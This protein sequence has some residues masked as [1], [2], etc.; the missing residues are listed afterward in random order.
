MLG[1]TANRVLWALAVAGAFLLLPLTAAAQYV[2]G[3]GPGG[4]AP[5]QFVEPTGTRT[6][7]AFPGFLGGMSVTLGDVNGDGV[8]DVIAGAGPGGT[9]HIKVFNGTDLSELASFLA[10]DPGFAGGVHVA[11]GD[12]DGDGRADIIIGAG[13]GGGPHV[14]VFSGA[15]LSEI[16]GFFAYNPLFDGGV[17]V[18]AGDINGD[19]RSDIVTGAGAGGGPHVRVF[20]GLDLSELAGFFAYDPEFDGG[21]NVAAG[22]IDGDGLSD[23][24]TAPGPGGGPHVRV[25]SGLDL[26]ELAG[27]YAFNPAFGGGVRVATGDI[28]G[29]G[30]VDLIITALDPHVRILSG[31]DLSEL[32]SFM[33]SPDLGAGISIGSTGDP[34]GL[35]FTSA[36]TTTFAA[37]SAGTFTVTTSGNPVP[38]I[39]QTGT[40]PAGVTFTD[41]GDGT[42]T[43]AGT[44]G[45]GSGG[46][47]A[48]T[49]TADN[50]G[51]TRPT[52]SFTLTVNEAPAITSAAATNFTINAAGT[53]A[54]TTSGFPRPAITRTGAALPAGVIWVDN[55]DGTGTLSGTPDAS[56][57]GTYAIT[58]TA[59][60]GVSP[61]ATQSFTLT[62]SG[63][64]TITSAAAATF[65]VGSAGSFTVT[66]VA[67]PTATISQTGTL[68]GNVAFTPNPDGTG[69]LSG[70][71]LAGT[72]GTYPLTFTA[73]NSEGTAT[74]SFTLT[75]HEAPAITSP[76]ATT[77]TVGSAGSFTVVMT[78]VPAPTVSVTAG[79]LPSGV[80]LSP[81]GVL[82]GTPDPGTGGVY[83]PTFTATNGVGADAVQVFTLTVNQAPAITSA[84]TASFVVN[85]AAT[86]FQVVMT[87]FPAPTVSVTAGTLPTG[88]TLSPAG[89]LSGTPTQ[90]GMFPVTLTA[91]N[92]T[93]P[94]ATQA[95][96]VVV[97]APPAIT[98]ANATTFRVG[99]AGSFTV[100]MTGVPAPTVSVTG[101][102]LPAGVTLSPAG[103]LSGT[104][105]PGTAGVYNLTFTATNG[106]GAN[107]VQPFT[108]TVG[109]VPRI[110]LDAND[111]GGTTGTD[112]AITFTEGGAAQFIE[113]V[114]DAT[115]TDVDSPTLTSITVTITNVLDALQE[116]LDV[117]LVT[118]G[119]NANFTKAFDETTTPGV[120][121]LTITTTTPQ[122]IADFNTLLRR[123][124]YQNIDTTGA[125]ATAPRTITFVV[126]DGV[127]NSNTATT[128]VTIAAGDN[129][130][131]ADNDTYTVA[132]GGT[133]TVPAPGVLDGDV[134]PEGDAPITAVLV[135]SPA[136]ASSFTLNSDGSFTYTHNGSETTT[137]AFTYRAVANG[138]QSAPATV[139]I[140][141]TAV[142]DAPTAGNDVN[143]TTEDA[144]VT[145]V[146]PGV[147]ANDTDPEGTTLTVGTVNGLAANV[148]VAV[149]LA[150]GATVTLNANGSYTYNPGNAF[151][152]LTAGQSGTDTFSYTAQDGGGAQS[153]PATVTI[154]ITGVND[155]PAGTNASVTINEDATHVFTVANFGFTDPV[156]SPANALLAV[157][158]ATLPA[159]GTLTLSGGA[160][161]VGQSI[162]VANVTAGNLVFTPAANG[163]G[164]PYTSFTFQV[165]DDG[166]TANG[167][168]DL[169]PSANTLTINVTAI[170]DAPAGTNNTVTML[171]DATRAFTVADFGFT[172]PTDAP[173]N[174][175]QSVLITTLPAAGTITL[176]G[177]GITAG[178]EIAVANITAGQLAFTPAANASGTP[179]TS[180]TFQVRDNGG[181]ANG[182][183]DLDA[184]PNTLTINVTALNDAPAGTN[185]TVTTDE[186]V[187]HIFTVPNFGFT[188]PNDTPANTLQS[189]VITTL[190]AV[191][192]L[193]LSGATFAAGTEILVASITAGNL[194]YLSPPNAF[195]SPFTTFTFQVRDNGGTAS[196]GVDLDPSANTM[197]INV[198]PVNDA[199]TVVN[200]TFEVLGNTEL[201]VDM[202]PGTT[203]HTSE[204][205]PNANTVEGVL[206]ND[207][208]VEGD[209][210]AVTGIA[211]C[212]VP[213]TTPPFDCTLTNGAVVHVA[214][215]GEFSY[216]PAP[217]AT[218][219]SFTYTVTDTPAAGIPVSVTGTVTLTLFDMI[220]YVDADA[221]AGG[222]GT[223][224]LPFNT[225]T[226]ATLSGAN[227]AGDL[228]DAD[229]YIFVHSAT[230]AIN[231]G[232]ELEVGQ[233]LIGEPAGLSIPRN[234]NSNG[235]PTVVVPVS[236]GT[237]P[238]IN[239][240]AGN[241]VTVTEAMPAEI[242][243][244]T[245]GSL[246]A[247]DVTTDAALPAAATL[248]IANNVI[249]GATAEGIDVNLNAGTTGTLTLAIT[250]NTWNQAGTHA[251]NAVDISRAAGTLNLNFSSNTNILSANAAGAAVVINGGAAIST[252]ITGFAANS[253]DGNT[254]GGGV[255]ISNVTFDATPGGTADTVNAG[256]LTVGTSIN[257]IGGAG[258][259]L[260]PVAGSLSFADLD[261]FAG[262][263]GL[264]AA[265]LNLSVAPNVST[266]SA[267]NGVGVDFNTGTLDLRLGGLTVTSAAAG[268][269]LNALAAGSQFSAATGSSIT[270]TS[271]A[272]TAFSVASS[273]VTLSYAGSLNVTSGT[274][275]SLT[276]NNAASTFTFSGGMTLTTGANPAFT[277]TG[278][279][280]V[281]VCDENPCNPAVGT[282][283]NTITTTTGTA[284]N[285]ANTTIGAGGLTFRS[286]SSGV[287]AGSGPANGINLNTTG[288]LGGL[289]ITG[290]GGTCTFATPTCTGGTIQ[291]STGD[292]IRLVSTQGVSLTRMRIHDND[293]N[294]IYGDE[295][296]NFAL[297]DSVVSDNDVANPSAFE[298]GVKFNELYGTNSISNTVV[299]GTKGDNIRLEMASGTLTNLTL[300]SV[301]VGPTANVGGGFSNGFS[302]VTSG[303]PGPTV[304]V[305]VNT[306]L[307]TGLDTTKQQSSGILTS[308]GGGTTTLSILN[309]DFEHENIG[310]DL[311]AS[312]GGTHRFNVDNNDVTFH[313]TNAIN[314]V[315][316]GVLN[317]TVN[318]NRVGNGT[319]DSGSMNSF[320]IAASQ[321]GNATWA[322]A[323]TNNT[324]RNSDFEGIFVRTGDFLT[325][326]SGTVNLTLTGNT[327]FTPDDNSGFPANPKGMHLRSRQATTLCMNIANNEA[328]GNGAAGYHLQESDT[329]SLRFQDF[330]TNAVTTLTNKNNKTAG[331]A[332]T[333]NE[334]G[335]PFA[336]SCTPTLPSFP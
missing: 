263:S 133:L 173:A 331:G 248:T 51:A 105:D 319:V 153:L 191:G 70:T 247:I 29:D 82:S 244:L 177:V 137:D 273:N 164:T 60:N 312:A 333:T 119:F 36:L 8:A 324:V 121:V 56:V 178:A 72:G 311:G 209:P 92:G 320:G 229:D 77:F 203:P 128:T 88:L 275:V 292:A 253:I 176:N 100:V 38:A 175:L 39:T 16:A 63:A 291:S 242:R 132:E 258:L 195:G 283:V 222:N 325:G 304:T 118:G 334:V 10:F 145:A 316:D 98:S 7:D 157:R 68:P 66:T 73:T 217:G 93:L 124:T 230:V 106:I 317:G 188:D 58:F 190:P 150:N 251:G 303:S 32:A 76:S 264:T 182:G 281:N 287:A 186:D 83:N 206:D 179:Y 94:D 305:T 160:V 154:T 219:G 260:N 80:T 280:T 288:A 231:A 184:T 85:I 259:V 136:N 189:V 168:V 310:I 126:N 151:Q 213:D 103:L 299:R 279:G 152:A 193:T 90:S 221:P 282:L 215:N 336:G 296:T 117:D 123:V 96:T 61:A 194:R 95:F 202:T 102:T 267:P 197:T 227:G 235:S 200:E 41:N 31:V 15:N 120:A 50:G 322:L 45:A 321:R 257:P 284:L 135:T 171:E 228:D 294:G 162:P 268:V 142:N 201:R 71:P 170:N 205:T 24:V 149:T 216:T 148:G 55:G 67:T 37:G 5:I 74:Q 298:A 192:S 271:G 252:F 172:D 143:T 99:T 62:I 225:F 12:V 262:T 6:I 69:T 326:D 204:T 84:N 208:D 13:P 144:S 27:F 28:D 286:I 86:P 108:L 23:V 330:N 81:A 306:S 295:L 234:L 11:A 309:S 44:P 116:K 237:P 158:I 278:G 75:V 129:P 54:V 4:T 276:S 239:G 155:A 232:I 270:K 125:N 65:T 313:R 272:G 265:G 114:V 238:V 214:A 25:F 218:T 33:T 156:D 131:T 207:S 212:T 97:N 87:G 3:P 17:T 104:P 241:S 2:I 91:T 20:S 243:G 1:K 301:T 240:G 49:F 245:L 57:A 89:L 308:I 9:P 101:G 19:G 165:Q 166:G 290:N 59:D 266:I 236:A 323:I 163:S 161:S 174:T 332:P 250:G 183:V 318:N 138:L 34:I 210:F 315:G 293:T 181:T 52:Q 46:S 107:A 196:G 261:V 187:Q 329:S 297:A 146:A 211:N 113:D 109:D 314:L 21:V 79:T 185:T 223:S 300:T 328:Q 159:A 147:L 110:D 249:N 256:V 14:R 224:R 40:L 43:L 134:D 127:G 198:N 246:N 122:P 327:V 199:P 18:A 307:F 22:D 47:Y 274:G 42:A 141:I 233:H 111:D 140:T 289:T 277:A 78:G 64:P 26:S 112:F 139:T 285:V 335:A 255:A 180:F 30:R 53:F 302:I 269:S 48:L 130:P 115:I 169:D 226:A 254:A 220:W 167:G 35:R